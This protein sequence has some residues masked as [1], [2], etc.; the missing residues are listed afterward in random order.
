M[1]EKPINGILEDFRIEFLEIWERLPNKLFFFVL[2]A[3]WLALFQFFGSS[4]L[5]YVKSS[6]LIRW[7]LDAYQPAGDYL[8]SDEAHAVLVPFVV[9]GLFWWKR[10]Q[11]IALPLNAWSP[12]IL[13]LAFSLILHLFGY[14]IQQPKLSVIALFTGIY[15]IT[16]LAWGWKWLRA[17][18]FPFFLFAFCMPMGEQ[19]QP[20]TFNLRLLVSWLVEKICHYG[21][22]IDV[23]R[24]GTKLV[25][26][27]GSYQY[28]VAAACSGMRSQVATLLLAIIYAF[29][30]FGSWWKRGVLIASAFPLAVMGNLL[31][32][33]LI[34]LAAEVGGQSWGNYVHEGGPLGIFSLLPYVPAFAGLILLGN[35]LRDPKPTDSPPGA[36]TVLPAVATPVKAI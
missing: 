35:W 10:K 14:M 3:A 1:E 18:F 12:G 34:I 9:L 13:I 5:G 15:G 19:A 22:A 28:E 2:L 27:T 36:A 21:L 16:G 30:S 6:S 29:V 8:N 4:T 31:R 25:D 32:M 17:S 11:L 26:P 7:M 24:E 33:L 20:I 23:V